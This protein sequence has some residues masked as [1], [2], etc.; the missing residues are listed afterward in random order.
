MRKTI[1]VCI[2]VAFILCVQGG[3]KYNLGVKSEEKISIENASDIVRQALPSRE[4]EYHIQ[5]E[6]ETTF[7]GKTYYVFHVFTVSSQ[8]IEGTDGNEPFQMQFTYGFY[9]VDPIEKELFQ[10]SV[11]GD[12]LTQVTVTQGD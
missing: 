6:K 3:C 4:H 5:Y 2:V 1:I 9:Y 7:E 8:M 11:G 10:L 12:H